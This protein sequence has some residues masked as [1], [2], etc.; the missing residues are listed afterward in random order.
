MQQRHRGAAVWQRKGGLS[1][2]ETMTPE[3]IRRLRETIMPRMQVLRDKCFVN[4]AHTHAQK[5]RKSFLG[6]PL[7]L[8][9][10]THTLSHK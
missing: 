1:P 9:V 4:G 8:L 7:Q 10:G 5:E 2:S 3:L 6:E